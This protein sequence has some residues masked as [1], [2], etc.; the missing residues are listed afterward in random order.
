MRKRQGTGKS[1]LTHVDFICCNIYCAKPLTD[2]ELGRQNK[3]YKYRFCIKCRINM[4]GRKNV[5]IAWRCLGCNI[6]I[7]NIVRPL[8]RY[9]CKSDGRCVGMRKNKLVLQA[10]W[11]KRNKLA[12]SI[13]KQGG[14]ENYKCQTKL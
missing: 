13:V 1:K 11:Y 9:H 10:K 6:L 2:Y 5:N 7:P 8:G 12:R 14:I 4:S 3:Q